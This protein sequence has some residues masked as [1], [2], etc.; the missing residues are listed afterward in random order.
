[1]SRERIGDWF[2]EYPGL[3]RGANWC[4]IHK[5][6]DGAPT[7]SDGPVA[8]KRCFYGQTRDDVLAQIAEYEEEDAI[9]PGQRHIMDCADQHDGAEA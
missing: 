3:G 4:A 1:V 9:T 8:D 7:Y 6:F 2:I 5:D